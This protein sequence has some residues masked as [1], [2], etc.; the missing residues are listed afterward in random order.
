MAWTAPRTWVVGEVLTA[1]LLNTH[2][3]DNLLETAPAKVTTAEDILVATAGN[4]LKRL[5][6]GSDAEVLTLTAGAVGWAAGAAPVTATHK[7]SDESLTSDTALQNDD[8]LSFA[9]AAN[10]IVYVAMQLH[11]T[12]SSAGRF[13][14][15]FT[16]PAS[17]TEVMLA[18]AFSSNA[19]S[20]GGGANNVLAFSS[21]RAIVPAATIVSMVLSGVI[22]NGV[23]AG[24][25]QLQW[26]QQVSN[27]TATV[28]KA[29]SSLSRVAIG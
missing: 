8:D 29:G 17:P 27:G 4:A 15:Q 19:S 7:S 24:T 9:I 28:V 11:I 18:Y 1:A 14:F 22:D 16:G 21:A 20:A 12:T 10:E 13:N 2:L 23:N 25:V 3:R 5:G 26:A 6:K